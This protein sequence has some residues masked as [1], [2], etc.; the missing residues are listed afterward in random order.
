MAPD[1]SPLWLGL[2]AAAFS[3]A[4]ALVLGPWLAYWLQRYAAAA[5][6]AWLPLSVTPVLLFAYCLR[7][8]QFRWAAAGLIASTFSL[9]YVMR[10]SAAAYG[11][12]KPEYVNAARGLGAT[13]W[14]VFARIAGPLALRPILA[15]AAFVFAVVAAEAGAVL[16]L[17]RAARADATPAAAPLAAIAAVSLAIHYLGTR[18]ERG[19]LG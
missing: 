2:R 6:L 1:W 16:I 13:E 9:P 8:A 19:S 17:V 4:M 11:A 14:R 10:A 15:A 18:L 5:P 12:L 7:A 3:S